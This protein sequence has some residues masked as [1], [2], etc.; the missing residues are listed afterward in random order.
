MKIIFIVKT[1]LLIYTFDK[2]S[3]NKLFDFHLRVAVIN[4]KTKE[5][6]NRPSKYIFKVKYLGFQLF[7]VLILRA[8]PE[9]L[10]QSK[11]FESRVR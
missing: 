8:A 1:Y 11:H 10:P 3:I 9:K 4:E 2:C 7:E 6:Y 5:I